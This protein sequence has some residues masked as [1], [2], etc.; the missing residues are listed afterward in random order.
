MIFKYKNYSIET[1]DNV[2]EPSDDTYL[3]ISALENIVLKKEFKVLEVGCGTGIISISLSFQVESAVACD[4]NPYAV[5]LTSK[6]FERNKVHNVRVVGSDLF[7]NVSGKFDLI[8]F[9]TPYLPQ[10]PD[11]A[12]SGSINHAWDGGADGRKVIDRFLSICPMFLSE[13]GSIVF[14][15]SSLSNYEKSINYLEKKGFQVEIIGRQKLHF[16]ELVVI[17]AVKI[18]S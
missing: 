4:I 14:L 2:Y 16:E 1:D 13:R 18:L 17:C 11:E 9:N 6:N 12:V 5:E 3:L 8:V 10:S 7:S 15:E